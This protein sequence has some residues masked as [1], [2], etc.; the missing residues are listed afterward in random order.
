MPTAK[1]LA[2]IHLLSAAVLTVA[3]LFPAMAHAQE[4]TTTTT[5]ASTTETGPDQPTG[6]V[7]YTYNEET[8]M[9]ENDKYIWDPV[10]QQTTPKGEVNYSY[11]P[12]TGRWDTTEWVY[13]PATNTYEANTK[14]TS[15]SPTGSTTGTQ[16]N[17]QQTTSSNGESGPQ[18]LSASNE[19][20][21]TGNTSSRGDGGS[22]DIDVDSD[23]KGIY[24]MFYNAAISNSLQSSAQSGDATVE[25]NTTAGDAAT[26]NANAIANF[27]NSIA[28]YWDGLGGNLMTFVSNIYNDVFGDLIIDPSQLVAAMDTKIN[29]E[30]N[31]DVTVNVDQNGQ[32]NN[33]I[34]LNAQSGD[35]TV[36][37]N[38]TAGNAA[39]G[40]ANTVANV[41]N[42]I[43]SAITSGTSFMGTLNIHGSLDGDI[44]FPKGV[45]E[46]LLAANTGP[47]S[48]FDADLISNKELLADID[49]STAINNNV[50][51]NAASGNAIVDS[52]TTGGSAITGDAL[53]NLTILNLTNH[54]VVTSNALLVFVNV[55]GEWVGLIMDAPAGTTAAAIGGPDSTT[56]INAKEDTTI[57]IAIDT[58]HQ[59]NNNLNLNS[60]SGDAA[61]TNNTTGGDAMTGNAT[62]SANIANMVNTGFDVSDWF[63]VLFVNVFG[64]WFGSF[65]VD[66][67]AGEAP[68]AVKP[69]DSA[70][71]KDAKVF[72][73]N[74]KTTKEGESYELTPVATSIT[75]N[76]S[77]VAS[78]ND[79]KKPSVPTPQ[80]L[81]SSLSEP[82]SEGVMNAVENS[83]SYLWPLFG[84]FTAAALLGTERWM[85][86]RGENKE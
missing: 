85:T 54:E 2:T 82:V 22:L 40:D 51:L 11:N 34:D 41:I 48:T 75:Y 45:L 58:N 25:G 44:L 68:V 56:T 53:T 76:S 16:S 26:G 15:S 74:P 4:D 42:M 81:V 63:G 69:E 23:T 19:E 71:V 6:E 52:N 38:T 61:V 70:A 80:K 47:G 73:F 84:C 3:L 46:T 21:K 12:E 37:S 83:P 29:A 18:A 24:D 27:I 77:S 86:V 17:P 31:T 8:G 28:S 7:P 1:K 66:T 59:I 60:R 20:S 9:W 57:D 5:Q 32:I 49:T 55:L 39:T 72:R 64:E 62:A 43:N 13:N 65:G 67:S 35:A 50:D 14:T 79:D 78:E 10:T 36:D 30:K 33:D